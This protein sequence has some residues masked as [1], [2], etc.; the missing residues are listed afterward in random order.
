LA[1]MSGR[2]I[3]VRYDSIRGRIFDLRGLVFNRGVLVWAR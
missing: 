3:A 1:S 2:S